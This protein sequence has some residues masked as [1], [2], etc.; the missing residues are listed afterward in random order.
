MSL[1]DDGVLSR[2]HRHSLFNPGTKI[3][4]EKLD[5]E[6]MKSFFMNIFFKG[7]HLVGGAIGTH[8]DYRF[9]CCLDFAGGV[10]KFEDI[11]NRDM[12][13]VLNK[14]DSVDGDF[15]KAIKSIINADHDALFEKIKQQLNDGVQV[16]LDYLFSQRK[17]TLTFTKTVGLGTSTKKT[18]LSW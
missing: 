14:G 1:A 16:I 18:T 10:V 5:Y 3:L 9:M 4:Y 11:I 6:N 8:K 13:F 15:V 12:R 7:F 17:A 2:G